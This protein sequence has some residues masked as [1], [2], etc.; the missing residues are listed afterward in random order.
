MNTKSF[1]Q[2]VAIALLLIS[3]LLGIML[4]IPSCH[5]DKPLDCEVHDYGWVTVENSTYGDGLVDV[6][7]GKY[8]ENYEVLLHDGEAYEYSEIP[9]GPITIWI[10]LDLQEWYFEY[11][12]LST[13]E[14]MT[15]TWYLEKKKSSEL[16]PMGTIRSGNKTITIE[17]KLK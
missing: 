4:V 14:D 6:T 17:G 10:T 15:F 13:C 11:K 5:R 3:L 8:D 9:A 2:Q 7:W 12:D 1:L 16:I